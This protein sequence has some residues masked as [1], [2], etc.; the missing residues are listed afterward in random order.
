[1]IWNTATGSAKT[2]TV[3]AVRSTAGLPT[4]ADIWMVVEYLGSASDPGGSFAN[5]SKGANF[6]AAT[7][8]TASGASWAGSPAGTP[9]AMTVSITP[10]QVGPITVYVRAATRRYVL[11]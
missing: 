7:S 9:F 10:Q 2:I 8:Y 11:R 6:A 3:N 4:N 1:M 5:N